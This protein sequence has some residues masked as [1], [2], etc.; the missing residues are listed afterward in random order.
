MLK[1][2]KNPLLVR[3][4]KKMMVRKNVPS[5]YPPRSPSK[6]VPPLIKQ[7]SSRIRS[8]I[9]FDPNYEPEMVDLSDDDEGNADPIV[10]SVATKGKKMFLKPL[11]SL[12]LNYRKNLYQ[13][14]QQRR[15]LLR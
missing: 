10:P 13:R 9:T 5:W 8:K 11:K 4:T 12:L 3:R 2:K 6:V 7:R 14:K 1:L 15:L